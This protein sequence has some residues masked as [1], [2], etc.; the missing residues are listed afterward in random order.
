MTR[1]QSWRLRNFG[2]LFAIIW[3]VSFAGNLAS[4]AADGRADFLDVVWAAVASVLFFA[5]LLVILGAFPIWIFHRIV[6]ARGD[7]GDRLRRTGL[8]MFL[9]GSAAIGVVTLLT[10]DG[11]SIGPSHAVFV[12]ATVGVAS[13]FGWL[14]ESPDTRSAPH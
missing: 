9:F 2:R 4:Q 12:A 1:D 13:L 7:G 8:A 5:P 14:S 11:K 6:A 10:L 3:A